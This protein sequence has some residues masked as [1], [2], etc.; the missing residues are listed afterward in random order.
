M[1]VF[2]Q[3]VLASRALKGDSGNKRATVVRFIIHK[4]ALRPRKILA[5]QCNLTLEG[6]TTT[7]KITSKAS[8]YCVPEKTVLVLVH[9]VRCL[10]LKINEVKSDI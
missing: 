3:L 10:L 8:I 5:E 1:G 4:Y 2:V 6:H 7:N 9:K